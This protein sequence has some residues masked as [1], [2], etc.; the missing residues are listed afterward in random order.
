MLRD[1]LASSG[2]T[3]AALAREVG[4]QPVT[5]WR[6]LDGQRRPSLAA[7]TAVERCTGVPASAWVAQ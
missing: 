7:A 4:V 5:L 2:T 6:W 3:Q 1:W